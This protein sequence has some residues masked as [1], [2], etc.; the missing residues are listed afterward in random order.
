[1]RPGGYR[2]DYWALE[3]DE[4]IINPWDRKIFID[5]EFVVNPRYQAVLR[6]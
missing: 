3:T 6:D 5:G 1:V 2:P 4:T